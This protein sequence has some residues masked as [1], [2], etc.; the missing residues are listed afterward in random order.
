VHTVIATY[1]VVTTTIEANA[2]RVVPHLSFEDVVPVIAEKSLE[3][4]KSRSKDIREQGLLL[5]SD[6]GI[7]VAQ[8]LHVIVVSVLVIGGGIASS[9][10]WGD[11]LADLSIHYGRGQSRDQ[12]RSNRMGLTLTSG[13]PGDQQR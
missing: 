1:L 12:S 3:S 13:E 9:H 5:L 8:P 4:W 11:H 10:F 7:D 2:D 6:F